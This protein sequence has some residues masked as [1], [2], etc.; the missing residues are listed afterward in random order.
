[1]NN[2]AVVFD[3]GSGTSKV[4][5]AGD[6]IPRSVFPNIVGYPKVSGMTMGMST[7]VGAEAQTKRGVLNLKYP[8][9]HG[10]INN[11]D[12]MEKIWHHSFYNELCV[13][14]EDHHVLLTEPPLNPKQNREKM[15]QIMF[16]SFNTTGMF[17]AIQAVLSLYASG[18][19]TG[20]VVDSGDGVTHVVPI[21]QS[22]VL[23]HAIQRMELAGR[24]LTDYLIKLL[25]A[26]GYSLTTT[27]ERDIVQDVKE[28]LAYVALDFDEAVQSPSN[29]VNYELQ[30]G[31]FLEIGSELF[32]CPEPLFQPNHIGREFDGAHKMTFMS[33]V[34]CDSGL[35]K[36][37][38]ANVVL[39]GGN[40]MFPGLAERLKKE[41]AVLAPPST[42]IN[43]VTPPERKYLAWMGGSKMVSL[44]SFKEQWITRDDYNEVGPSIVHRNAA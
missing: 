30:D 25:A 17:V 9:E 14:P 6:D 42:E 41:M 3:N 10:I 33:I 44:P 20:V 4:G 11:W 22:A 18:R 36:D 35:W 27:A 1:M 16:E 13:A 37:L 29:L 23:P 43:I 32:R 8:I 7:F 5:F 21:Y 19:I 2:P 31:N 28:K 26:R 12:D 40:T 34:K 24:D 38:Y 39:S 15:A